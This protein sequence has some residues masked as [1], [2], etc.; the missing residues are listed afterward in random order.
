MLEFKVYVQQPPVRIPGSAHQMRTASG[1]CRTEWDWE[2]KLELLTQ[3][4]ASTADEAWK[5]ANK[6]IAHPVL[7]FPSVRYRKPK[8]GEL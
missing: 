6:L 5:L 2:A 8:E 4:V 3:G 7:E 1:T